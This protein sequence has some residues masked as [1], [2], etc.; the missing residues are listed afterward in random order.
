MLSEHIQL[1]VASIRARV[2]NVC[3]STVQP[4]ELD[5]LWTDEMFSH[6]LLYFYC[7][8]KWEILM[9]FVAS[10]CIEFELRKSHACFGQS[11]WGLLLVEQML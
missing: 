5:L 1:K 9:C 7:I 10:L 4:A 11:I 8:F 3:G 2:L 6:P